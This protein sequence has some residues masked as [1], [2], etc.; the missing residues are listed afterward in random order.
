MKARQQG[1]SSMRVTRNNW[2]MHEHGSRKRLSLVPQ[3]KRKDLS[4]SKTYLGLHLPLLRG[5]ND[6]AILRGN[7]LDTHSVGE[8]V[9][10]ITPFHCC[11]RSS[12]SIC[13]NAIPT[14][15]LVYGLY[16]QHSQDNLER[17]AI[18]SYPLPTMWDKAPWS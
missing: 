17:S 6:H 13:N 3:Y 1:I 4:S 16:S 7:N 5:D 8:K 2:R 9:D 18:V 10:N 14:V 15:R 11:I 12:I